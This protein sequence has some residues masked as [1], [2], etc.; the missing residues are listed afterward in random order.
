MTLALLS[1]RFV[2]LLEPSAH[3]TSPLDNIRDGW[4][5]P[6]DERLALSFRLSAFSS[7]LADRICP[8]TPLSSVIM[9]NESGFV[10]SLFWPREE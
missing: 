10:E 2:H 7:Q 6:R 1:P 3:D 4:A 5:V 9:A 8:P